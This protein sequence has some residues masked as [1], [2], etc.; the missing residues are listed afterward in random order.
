MMQSGV[1]WLRYTF[2][3]RCT[4]PTADTPSTVWEVHMF[5][6]KYA[7]IT[8][9]SYGLTKTLVYSRPEGI[10]YQNSMDF[11]IHNIMVEAES[12]EYEFDLKDVWVT[13]SRWT[14]LV[15]QYIDP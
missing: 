6:Q 3:C 5:S 2:R 8:D 4:T 9:L 12:C 7:D 1:T 11:Q 13:S 14:N 10:D 15:R